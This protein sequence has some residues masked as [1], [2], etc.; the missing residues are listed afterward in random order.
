MPMLQEAIYGRGRLDRGHF[1]VHGSRREKRL[2]RALK[3][4]ARV[5]RS[6]PRELFRVDETRT[7]LSPRAPDIRSF[8]ASPESRIRFYGLRIELFHWTRANRRF[9][10]PT[11]AVL[12]AANAPIVDRRPPFH[13]S[14]ECGVPSQILT[15]PNQ[16][17]LVMR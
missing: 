2:S 1:E 17:P 5:G 10:G 14:F 8:S 16:P 4:T 9:A 12:S 7:R 11:I 6:S 15:S 3:L 13:G